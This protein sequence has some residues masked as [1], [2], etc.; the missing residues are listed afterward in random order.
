MESDEAFPTYDDKAAQLLEFLVAGFDTVGYTISWILISLAENKDEQS[1][2]RKS[3]QQLNSDTWNNSQELEWAIKE[4]M[5][6]NPV[7]SS[8]SVRTVGR[9]I[10]TRD[11]CTIPKGSICILSFILLFRNPEVFPEPDSFIP[12]R[13]KDPTREQLDAF[14]PFSMGKQNC[15]GQSLARAEIT[16][17]IARIISEFELSVDEPSSITSEFF[18]TLKPVNAILTARKV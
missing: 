13:W 12:S 8:G 3:L 7:A 5:R 10:I 18:L 1:K 14:Q 6:L 9:D 16:S 15:V 17:I 11:G 4:G 2:L